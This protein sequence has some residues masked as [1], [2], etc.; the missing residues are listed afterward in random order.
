MGS[1]RLV[2][3]LFQSF[4]PDDVTSLRGS[5]TEAREKSIT[6]AANDFG[7]GRFVIN[8]HSE[9]ALS[10]LVNT[11]AFIK[12]SIDGIIG[13]FWIEEGSDRLVSTDEAGGED[14]VRGGRGALAYLE[15]AILWNEE[16]TS[17]AGHITDEGNW[18][19]INRR[20]G[21]ILN[22]QLEEAQERGALLQMTWDFDGAEDSAGNPWDPV[23]DEFLLP[24]GM[25][26]LTM[27]SRFQSA[28][29]TIRMDHNLKLSAWNDPPGA[30]VSGSVI[31]EHGVNIREAADRR[32]FAS[33]AKSITLVQGTTR[34]GDLK[35]REVADTVVLLDD[36]REGFVEYGSTRSNN[37]LDRAGRQYLK[38]LRRQY[39]GPSVIGVLDRSADPH[40]FD[41]YFPGDTVGVLIPEALDDETFELS[42]ITVADGPAQGH[43]VSIG[44]E[45]APF[46]PLEGVKP[47][48]TS[49]SSHSGGG[50][51]GGGGASVC[52]CGLGNP[53]DPNGIADTFDRADTGTNGGLGIADCGYTWDPIGGGSGA[54]SAIVSNKFRLDTPSDNASGRVVLR[55]ALDYDGSAAG[56]FTV[57]DRT[58]TGESGFSIDM[59]FPGVPNA[60]ALMT[61]IP[62]SPFTMKLLLT[63]LDSG[64]ITS[65][66]I[67]P[68]SVS[69]PHEVSWTITDTTMTV[70]WGGHTTTITLPDPPSDLRDFALLFETA[71]SGHFD[72]DDLYLPVCVPGGSGA[73]GAESVHGYSSVYAGDTALALEDIPLVVGQMALIWY[74]SAG[75]ITVSGASHVIGDYPGFAWVTPNEDGTITVTPESA[76]ETTAIHVVVL[77]LG[78]ALKHEGG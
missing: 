10:G 48:S 43:L 29:V 36:R 27:F 62:G 2:S 66:T 73:F 41:D 15:R 37:L 25:D 64:T 63:D 39:N 17:G 11:G 47:G 34:S 13:A 28:G 42:T 67:T 23:D 35:F 9:D 21:Q 8:R 72:G 1:G 74:D 60:R 58:D 7:E 52:N 45:D 69:T 19:W 24:I 77:P 78:E 31:F 12:A 76:N 4:Y 56:S 44:F 32:V 20:I 18:S 46:E 5:L 16:L 57:D 30:D 22:H 49:S 59:S 51:K 38:S 26:L 14:W 70:I 55:G 33:P 68:G 75:G 40:P 65:D 61:F 53:C 3:L 50:G 6:V 54:Q 71:G